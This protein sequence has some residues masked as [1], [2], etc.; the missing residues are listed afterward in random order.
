MLRYGVEKSITQSFIACIAEIYSSKRNQ[1]LK[2]IKEIKKIIT[3]AITIDLFIK[4][5]NGS[6]VTTFRNEKEFDKTLLNSNKYNESIFLKSLD[7]TNEIQMKF[8]INIISS[9]ER[10]IQYINDD[11]IIIDH[12]YLWDA[13]SDKNNLLIKDGL[14]LIVLE[15]LNNDITENISLICP[16]NTNKINYDPEKQT[17]ILLKNGHY[18]QPIYQYLEKN[19]KIIIT[20]EFTKSSSITG[21]VKALH[22]LHSSQSKYCTKQLYSSPQTYAFKQ[23][24]NV[25]TMIK[26]ITTNQQYT[27]L[28]QISN[29]QTKCI[30]LY[31]QINN[32]NNNDKN[33]NNKNNK[34]FLPCFPSEIDVALKYPIKYMDDVILWNNLEMTIHLL[35]IINENTTIPCKPLILVRENSCIIG[36]LTETNQFIQLSEPEIYYEEYSNKYGLKIID[37]MNYLIADKIITT[38]ITDNKLRIDTIKLISIEQQCYNAFKSMVRK[39]LNSSNYIDL[40]NKILVSS[41]SKNTFKKKLKEVIL[42]L[43]ELLDSYVLFQKIDHKVLMSFNEIS[44]CEQ[45]KENTSD[46]CLSIDNDNQ[47]I[48][49]KHNL[50]T[51]EQ[52]ETLYFTKMADELIRNKRSQLYMLDPNYVVTSPNI[53][54]SVYNNELLLLKSL[55][56]EIYKNS[57]PINNEYIQNISYDNTKPLFYNDQNPYVNLNT[58]ILPI[59]SESKSESKSENEVNL[60]SIKECINNDVSNNVI[61]NSKS[62]FRFPNSYKEFFFK[63]HSTVCS[64][65]SL[66]YIL[67]MESNNKQDITIRYIQNIL[68]KG[69]DDDKYTIFKDV[70]IDILKKQGKTSF[71]NKIIKKELTLHEVIMSPEYF[72]TDLD[73]WIISMQLKLPI[74]LFNSTSLKPFNRKWIYL[75]S[76]KNDYEKP[77]YFLRSPSSKYLN[78]SL[79]LPKINYRDLIGNILLEFEKTNLLTLDSFLSSYTTMLRSEN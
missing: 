59:E 4:Y 35:N 56:D 26:I 77:L 25:S 70:I 24:I 41:T 46:Y 49:P 68:C 79:I 48:L 40:R 61:G 21:M 8:L 14:N 16:T 20:K 13:I 36:L 78:Y 19:N 33:K 37:D 28:Y 73:V 44:R 30:G 7:K 6:L 74:I 53:Q 62:V 29:Y 11:T 50:F 17:T 15:I 58:I 5:Q 72:I 57:V 12:K 64:Y 23:N 45:T 39:H 43:H 1:P 31:I 38:S 47:I 42:L 9:Y 2:T 65:S 76:D 67:I 32:N 55:S 54:Y 60:E 63:N 69:Y 22:T 52:N 18:Y 34:I 27:I 71:M 51:N 3:N 66:I 75:S 10:F